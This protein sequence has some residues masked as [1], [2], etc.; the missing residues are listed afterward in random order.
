MPGILGLLTSLNDTHRDKLILG[1]F[2]DKDLLIY[3][4][5]WIS[6]GAKERENGPS[7]LSI[8]Q[9]HDNVCVLYGHC[10]DPKAGIR[11]GA[12][13]FLN[14]WASERKQLLDRLEG[15][16]HFSIWDKR[17]KKLTIGNDR[18]GILPLY[19]HSDRDLFSFAPRMMLLARKNQ[20]W[21]PAPGAVINFL[22][23]GHYL[24]PSTQTKQARLLT[25][26]TILSIEFERF[27]VEETRYWNLVYS[28]EEDTPKN[29]HRKRLGEA[30]LETVDLMTKPE[31]G[32]SGIFLSG[33]WDSRSILGAAIK[34]DRI[35]KRVISN[36][37]S[38][39]IP[40]SDTWMSK[41]IAHDCNI[42]Y[43][44]CQRTPDVDS[45]LWLDGVRVGEITTA[46]NPESFGQHLIS[47][48]CFSDLAY[49][50]KGDVTW[51]SGDRARS[52]V[53][54]IGKIIPYPLMDKVKRVLHPDLTAEADE[55]YE[56]E[57]DG[58]MKYCENTDWTDRRDY[59]WQMGGINRY[60]L[61]LGISDEE[62]T[63]VRRPLLSGKVFNVYTRVPQR[64]RVLKNLFIETI[65]YNHPHL[66][67]YG[68]N[69]AS[70]IA[71]YYYYMAPFVRERTL[72]HLEAG[73]NLGGLLDIG[74]CKKVIT[75]FNPLK[76]ILQ[77]PKIRNR[78]YYKF[79]DRYSYLWHRSKYFKEKNSKVFKTSDTMLAF[80]IYLLIEWFH[81]NAIY[82][83]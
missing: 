73:H 9:G 62:H 81:G 33:G 52:R 57:I 78:I 18:I 71:N 41:K 76:E 43:W 25:P 15:A 75:N 21:N 6:L 40:Y 80:H 19:W 31:E 30:I 32:D 23:V 48:E 59:L 49:V 64:L 46:N 29:E 24:G 54:S 13:Y 27:E 38:D 77:S 10:L 55:L 11:I 56:S 45:R 67:K 44:F 3:Q 72:Q 65:K 36:G 22:S 35:P 50:L 8:F 60:I 74:E 34:L 47:P 28:A 37:I 82:V 53:M 4:D 16:F 17:A 14:Q 66:F 79:H 63:Q 69:H 51:G 42:P 1:G 5:R 83:E 61:G 2:E 39:Q 12:E 58:V 7:A 68:R 70:N 20:S 26:A